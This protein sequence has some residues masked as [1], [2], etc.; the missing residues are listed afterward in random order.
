[1]GSF[2]NGFT[3]PPAQPGG[4]QQWGNGGYTQAKPAAAETQ[5]FDPNDPNFRAMALEYDPE[6]D[7]NEVTP[8]VIPSG[9]IY[10]SNPDMGY[11]VV[12]TKAEGWK[13]KVKDGKASASCKLLLEI[14]GVP[15]DNAK[16]MIGR[17][18]RFNCS[19]MVWASGVSSAQQLIQAAGGGEALKS[20]AKTPDTL[21]SF[22]DQIVSQKIRFRAQVDWEASFYDKDTKTDLIPRI[23]GWRSFEVDQKTGLPIPEITRTINGQPITTRAQMQA[24]LI[25]PE[26]FSGSTSPQAAAPIMD[27]SK[28]PMTQAAPPAQPAMM[29]LQQ[30]QQSPFAAQGSPF[31]PAPPAQPAQQT[32]QAPQAPPAPPAQPTLSFMAPPQQ[33]APA[34]AAPASAPADIFARR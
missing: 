4:Q 25:T 32:A 7:A 11:E 6:Q 10:G 30:T 19:T 28:A 1:M 24:R 33:A 3:A 31:T 2:P 9:L 26:S 8:P 34:A 17:K 14:V 29:Q 13:G 22:V 16:D 20:R 18:I 12:A 27:F 21:M 15:H 23:R 5:T